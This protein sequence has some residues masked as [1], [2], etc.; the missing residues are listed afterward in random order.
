[1]KLYIGQLVFY[2]LFASGRTRVAVVTRIHSATEADLNVHTV[3]EDRDL[4]MPAPAVMPPGAT[5]GLA[6]P[7]ATSGI[8]PLRRVQRGGG[9]GM[10]ERWVAVDA[11]GPSAA[12]PG[13]VA[14]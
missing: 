6:Y 1:M 2:R 10:W 7:D 3:A 9:P 12:D 14:P 11:P 8:Q 13:A 5:M 4:L